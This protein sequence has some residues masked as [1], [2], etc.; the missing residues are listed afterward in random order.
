M[1]NALE[2]GVIC[3]APVGV[4]ND[5]LVHSSC[6]SGSFCWSFCKDCIFTHSS[7]TRS[8]SSSNLSKNSVMCSLHSFY[9]SGLVV[10]AYVYSFLIIYGARNGEIR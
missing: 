1:R 10:I 4:R 6:S 7:T 3:G 2:H 9:C 5:P 8:C